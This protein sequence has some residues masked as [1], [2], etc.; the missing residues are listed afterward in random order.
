M[1]LESLT[2]IIQAITVTGPDNPDITGISYD[3]RQVRPG[4]LF[5][6]FQ[7]RHHEGMEFIDEAI[8]RGAVA[9]VS[10]SE[11]WSR[12]DICHVHV[13]DARR[14]LAEIACAFSGNP[15]S[16]LEVIGVTGT[17]GKTTVA[18]MVK[19]ILQAAGRSPGLIGTVLYEIGDRLIPAG[20]TTP[21]APELQAMLDQMIQAGC[22]S[23]VMEVSSHALDQKRVWGID[24][25]VGVFTN[26]TRDHLDY[27]ENMDNYFAAKTLLFRGLG[28]AQKVAAGVINIDDPWGMR[29]ASINGF[30]VEEITFGMH[31]GAVVRAE[32]IDV[33]AAGSTFAL[34][35][36]W[37]SS[38][39]HLNVLG[40][41]NVSNAL[42]AIAACGSLGIE[43]DLMARVLGEIES[44]PGRLE[45]IPNRRGMKVFVDYA[46][47]D[48]ALKNVLTTLREITQGRI[49][50]V[51]GCGGDRDRTKRPLM[52]SV[53]AQLADHS[54]VTTDNPRSEDPAAIARGVVE[55]F[56][57][58]PN[59][60]TVADR[61]EAIGRAIKMA[62]VGDV[63][64]IAGKGHENY[65]E[66]ANTVVP[67]DDR[68][69]ARNYLK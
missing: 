67:F 53:A 42:A 37:G 61:E 26:L 10:E 15:S 27:H 16:R 57:E 41:F 45:L 51:F 9:V 48:D 65:Q 47:T 56:G 63:V 29:L 31:P 19:A 3:S 35:S 32:E 24:F 34:K 6:A 13:E 64:L 7:G 60:E 46:H 12:R 50:L 54:I 21:E 5:V 38:R 14:A 69:A 17:N 20:R 36:P 62:Q 52:G 30:R 1:R 2:K 44:V 39:V 22:Q 11:T 28:Q 8:T 49:I 25:D 23:V 40:R 33:S 4:H 58:Y 18:F 55:G 43:P 66:F 68:E 59:Y